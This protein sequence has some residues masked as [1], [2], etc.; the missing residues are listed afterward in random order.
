[1]QLEMK[2]P[3]LASAVIACC[4]TLI[5]CKPTGT[6]PAYAQSVDVSADPSSI[7][8][9]G[10]STVSARVTE[11][12]APKIGAKIVF[13]P[14]GN[15]GTLKSTT[16]VTQSQTTNGVGL[17]GQAQV[18]FVANSPYSSCTETITATA[19]ASGSAVIMVTPKKL[20]GTVSG[21]T[22]A[23]GASSTVELIPDVSQDLSNGFS[24]SYAINSSLDIQSIRFVTTHKCTFASSNNSTITKNPNNPNIVDVV[25]PEASSYPADVITA[26]SDSKQVG[27]LTMTITLKNP[28]GPPLT[29]TFQGR[30]PGPK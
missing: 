9:G 6:Q 10:S 17:T 21:G 27:K 19:Q 12:L 4:L 1:M 7:E 18:V 22:P 8:S 3:V 11:A 23:S 25:E 30:I 28:G 26:K 20:E 16:A 29:V 2:P 5:S 13:T 15:C 14:S 24:C